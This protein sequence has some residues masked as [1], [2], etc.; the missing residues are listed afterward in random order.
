MWSQP[1]SSEPIIIGNTNII[2]RFFNL[3]NS[4]T[5]ADYL[6]KPDKRIIESAFVN[7]YFIKDMEVE[8]N[9]E[10]DYYICSDSVTNMFGSGDT[11]SEAINN[12]RLVLIE[13]LEFLKNKV[14]EKL[15]DS[16]KKALKYLEKLITAV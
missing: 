5:T 15:D 9:E 4:Q 7:N 1:C 6:Y 14:P 2:H 11:L 10:L 16:S 12:Y 8:V 13:F 3:F